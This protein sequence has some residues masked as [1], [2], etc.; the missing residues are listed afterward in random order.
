MTARKKTALRTVDPLAPV[1]ADAR[2]Y[3]D[4]Q[5]VVWHFML[6]FTNLSFGTYGN[7][8]FYMMQLI[9]DGDHYKVFRKWGRVGAK[10]PQ[11]AL[12]GHGKSLAKAL[13]SF[14]NKFLAKSG[15]EWP[16][17]ASGFEQVPGKYVLV[18]LDDEEE[19]V[20][21][22]DD[23][24]DGATPNG[25][26]ANWESAAPSTLH[27]HVQDVLKLICDADLI[28][29]EVAA[30][31]LDLKRLP[32]GRLSKTQISQGYTLLEKMATTVTEM[33]GLTAQDEQPTQEEAETT[34]QNISQQETTTAMS[35]RRTRRSGAT[36]VPVAPRRSTRPR[37]TAPARDKRL[38]QLKDQLKALSGEFYSLIPHDFGRALPPVID[39]LDEIKL[40]IDLLEVLADIEISQKLQRERRRAASSTPSDGAAVH[41]LDA[42][43]NLLGVDLEPLA[44]SEPDFAVL[45]QY[46]ETTHAPTHIQYKL[47][48]R[49]ILKL[50][51]PEEDAF[52]STHESVS[53]HQLLWHGSRL[54]NVVG[55]L[56]KGLRVA[57][58]EAPTNGYM[59]GKGIYFADSVSKSANYCWA[60]PEQPRGVLLL[61]DVALGSTLPALEAIDMDYDKLQRTHGCH[62]L[63]G[64]GRMA[65]PAESHLKMQDGVLV[66]VGEF[67]PTGVEGGELLYNEYVVYR[68]EQVR[69]RYLVALDFVYDGDEE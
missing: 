19:I 27:A 44:E 62:S 17:P 54:C 29:K 59:F 21:E 13:A 36:P 69:L 9:Q 7:N 38:R 25:S 5:G 8:K 68:R 24:G 45:R 55:I 65:A 3:E 33:A 35:T 57:P 67:E 49:S 14:Q 63:H 61:A 47:R 58:P 41:P 40:K 37:R 64:L 31:K 30:M 26:K 12:E 10:T 60:T 6:N 20:D 11:R 28:E 22:E 48:I 53:N 2:I 16:L 56:A 15:N 32:L 23:L 34:A 51:R 50:R 18:A 46:V 43:Y 52:A 42:Q 39:S 1:S 66:P 4:E